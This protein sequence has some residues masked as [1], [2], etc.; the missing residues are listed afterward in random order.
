MKIVFLD[1]GSMGDDVSMAPI[2]ALGEYC[3]YAATAPE[4][5]AA[6]VAEADV[7][8]TNKVRLT[9]ENVAGAIRTAG[10]GKL[11]LICVAATGFDNIDIA[12]A[13]SRGIGVCN[14]VG[15]ST[16]SVAQVTFSL[17]LALLTHLPIYTDFVDS[18]AYEKSNTC[19]LITPPFHELAGKTW[20][21]VGYGHIGA[22]VG[23][24][25]SAFGCHVIAYSRSPK[26]GVDWR[27]LPE[28][29]RESDIVSLHVPLSAETRGLIGRE[30]IA[31]M[32][33]G[34]VLINVARGAV[35][36]ESAIADAVLGGCLL[37]GCDVYSAEPLTPGH[38]ITRL[39]GCPGACLTPHMAWGSVEARTRCVA[40]I[41]ENIEAFLRGEGK[42]RVEL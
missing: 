40:A 25:A 15:Y 36:D 34:A 19:N 17:A 11:R 35:T 42:N 30:E 32:K 14:V 10:A 33:S 5:V 3:S 26:P 24:I 13:R 9:R 41:A 2:A 8:V 1:A 31:L 28:L 39:Y 23:A 7:I 22:R 37:Y 29:L 20:G 27:S 18:G 21:I 16:E 4:E 12:Y 38:P 6:R